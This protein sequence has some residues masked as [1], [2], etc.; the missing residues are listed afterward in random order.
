[1]KYLPFI[2]VSIAAALAAPAMAQIT[3]ATMS[4]PVSI[5]PEDQTRM[6]V[7]VEALATRTISDAVP[8]YIRAVDIGPL[9]ALNADLLTARAAHAMSASEY[10]R[11][12]KL[13]SQDQSASAQSV[14]AARAAALGDEAKVSLL[15]R[16]LAF[17]WSPALV[18]QIAS[19]D[20]SLIEA[21]ASGEAALI[22][23]D[24][25][26]RPDGI[27]GEIAA[28]VV[29]EEA[30]I[31]AAPLGLSGAADPRMQT[32]GLYAVVRGAGAAALRPGKVFNGYI[33]T[34]ESISGVVIPRSAIVRLDGASWAYVQTGEGVFARREILG[35]RRIEDGWFVEEGFSDGEKI[36]V[37]GAESVVAVERADESAEAD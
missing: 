13:A 34:P 11:L 24:A 17:E 18:A 16:R 30:P 31:V 5:S 14:E 8:A 10:A 33:R 21:L 19:G 36:V 29:R 23:A 26:Q 1:M 22:R 15:A 27:V 37:A 9:L 7:K 6:G 32:V 20:T 3:P 25:P 12:S 28:D 2:A 35:A 4:A